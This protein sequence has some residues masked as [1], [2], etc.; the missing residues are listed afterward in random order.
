MAEL[1]ITELEFD[2]IKQNFIKFLQA[3]SE[4]SDYDF[5]GSGI[6]V[7]LDVLAYNTHYNAM[8]AH[9]VANEMFI[10]S[11][12]KRSSVVSIAKTLGYVPQSVT[13]AQA[14]VNVSVSA[15]PGTLTI[16]QYSKFNTT[17]NNKN[18][19]FVT[20]DSKTIT[21]NT[22][23][24]TFDNLNII[25]GSHITQQVG[26]TSDLVSG[27]ISIKNN[28]VDISTIG[29]LVQESSTNQDVVTWNRTETVIGVDGDSK[30][31]WIEEG[32]DGY[33][34]LVFGDDVIGKKLSS[35]NIVIIDY[36]AS[37]GA[38]ANGAQFFNPQFTLGGGAPITTLVSS[39]SG[40][41]DRETTDS[42][43]F[44]APR[45]FTTQN[46]VVTA[47]DYK[48]LILEKFDKAKSVAVWGGE[49][50]VPPIY[51][52]VFIS[53]DPQTDYIITDADKF[54]LI[55]THIKPRSIL[56]LTHE[57]VDPVYLYVGLDVV[58][59]YNAKTTPF[60]AEQISSIVR[61]EIE[62]YF[63]T[64][65]STLDRKF[66]Y[67]QLVNNIQRSHKAIL[68]SL[69]N[70]RLQRRIVPILNTKEN[71][72]LY[73]T[74][75]IEPN[76]ITSS[77]FITTVAGTQYNAYVQDFPDTTPPSKTGTGTL[78][79]LN[80]DNDAIIDNN[81]GTV[82][83]GTSGLLNIPNFYVTELAGAS[84]NVRFNALPQELGKD[85]YPTI[86][87]TTSESTQAVYPYPSQNIIVTLDDSET[88]S[89]IKTIAGLSVTANGV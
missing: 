61:Q 74:T 85:L 56:S 17:V 31:F 23:T 12:M 3:Q 11:A 22:G 20:T 54:K 72:K 77:V 89:N 13:S 21:S 38:A 10:D 63:S 7:L 41:S 34:N 47:E 80:A 53:I 88:N 44:N 33:Y 36:I 30:V 16:P 35:G 82:Y 27:P 84:T 5:A 1:R 78:K 45:H 6:N 37:Q 57:F 81:Y 59:S 15:T 26:I 43:R 68:G 83:Y 75:P 24:F 60:T 32:T 8:L 62:R 9:L 69:I 67:A 79:L 70:I 50:N 29:V 51:G 2:Q 18:F 86:V 66:Y 19:T 46:R 39:A 4:F 64:E 58:V 49:D 42:I 55:N 40:G 73:F 25:E 71:L 52:K 76:S 14:T 48:A 87:R 65:L 28:N